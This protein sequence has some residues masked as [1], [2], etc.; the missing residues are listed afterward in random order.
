MG[1]KKRKTASIALLTTLAACSS[2]HRA[3]LEIRPLNTQAVIGGEDALE[4][5]DMLFRR[6][7]YALALDAYR[8]A[9]RHDPADAR[10]YDGLA[11][12]YAAMGRY[13]LSERFF[14]LALARAPTDPKIY[15]NMARAY[16]GQGRPD[17]ARRIMGQLAQSTQ[18]A[19]ADPPAAGSTLEDIARGATAQAAARSPALPRS[20][21]PHLERL[22]LGEV[23]L[24]TGASPEKRA[25]TNG[26][27][28]LA[29]I[30]I[31][32]A[33]GATAALVRAPAHRI[34]V[35]ISQG[36]VTPPMRAAMQAQLAL[37]ATQDRT[38]F[39]Q[40]E[41]GAGQGVS[42]DGLSLNLA[43]GL[44]RQAA[45]TPTFIA[46][47]A[48]PSLQV[49]PARSMAG[50]MA[51]CTGPDI[52]EASQSDDGTL[53]FFT[54]D[55]GSEPLGKGRNAISLPVLYLASGHLSANLKAAFE[56][57]DKTNC[58]VQT[59]ERSDFN[60]LLATLATDLPAPVAMV[61][62]LG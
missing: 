6:G 51:S 54:G 11:I 27:G 60:A 53:S 17:E 32:D 47:Q 55:F 39:T 23:L 10:G 48:A 52:R 31:A 58:A 37:N 13:D 57:G 38:A 18:T 33:S 59:V 46:W 41:A 4:R 1:G 44:T 56:D 14:E 30:E 24:S 34:S 26:Q 20:T 15:R 49:P 3:A 35:D 8:R 16:E 2:M 50:G 62:R 43:S 36:D 29:T 19:T 12:S 9:V 22:S 61:E 21:V 28:V 40:E 45:P 25:D 5:G 42:L 7:E